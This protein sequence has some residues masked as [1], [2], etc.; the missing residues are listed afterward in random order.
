MGF[1]A[2]ADALHDWVLE[3]L[4]LLHAY[5]TLVD[6]ESGNTGVVKGQWNDIARAL[7]WRP[8]DAD[9]LF[10]TIDVNELESIGIVA[11]G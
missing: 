4:A 8:S 6:E 2:Q 11:C 3:R 7:K 5:V 10:T 1:I 9:T